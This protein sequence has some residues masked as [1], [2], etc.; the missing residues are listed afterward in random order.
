MAH[1]G[2]MSPASWQDD[3]TYNPW[4]SPGVPAT[5]LWPEQA[6]PI[7]P[8]ALFTFNF[9][10]S[11]RSL[12]PVRSINRPAGKLPSKIKHST[13]MLQCKKKSGCSRVKAALDKL[14]VREERLFER[15]EKLLE[16]TRL[17]LKSKLRG[18][19]TKGLDGVE[20]EPA[21]ETAC[22]SLSNASGADEPSRADATYLEAPQW[23][24]SPGRDDSSN[25][26]PT[27]SDPE[28]GGENA[29]QVRH[30][31]LPAKH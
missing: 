6:F 5:T 2:A 12:A 4:D 24:S 19:G 28:V 20:H 21:E 3:V 1:L 30:T 23:L 11:P 22:S 10:S 27:W 13:G 8:L 29:A 14:V 31:Q 7:D 18:A 15:V 9:T 26:S 16:N 25:S 17:K